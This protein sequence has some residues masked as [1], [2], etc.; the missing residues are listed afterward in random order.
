MQALQLY[1]EQAPYQLQ[2]NHLTRPEPKEGEALVQIRAA[3]LNHRD[4]WIIEGKY[5]GIKT[6]VTLGSDGCGVV[7]A[8]GSGDSEAWI[9][10]EV[11]INPNINW[12]EDPKH[13]S[14]EYN[15]L[16]NPSNGTFATHL[17]CPID[18]LHLKPEHLNSQ[19]AASLPM[20]GLTAYRAV[21]TQGEITKDDTVL[22]SGIGGGVAQFAFQ[23]ALAIGAKVYVT[24]G[25]EHKLQA[26]LKMGALGAVNY[27][28]ENWQQQLLKLSGGFDCA[29]DSAGGNQLNT[30]VRMMK[31]S[32]R[33]ISYGATL[34][35]PEEL[36][37]HRIFYY[38]LKLQ[39]STMG[40]DEEFK[41]M[42]EFVEKHRI[43]PL[44]DMVIPIK[45]AI[46]A[47]NRMKDGDQFG[48]IIL[49]IEDESMMGKLKQ[50]LNVL[51]VQG[52]K[53]LNKGSQAVG[54]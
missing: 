11:I 29:I 3:A 35:K 25:S 32:G 37:I 54:L 24:S 41:E 26:A 1:G 13:Q 23:F 27:R 45:E 39:G 44:I 16:G 30:I 52:K 43:Y 18:R 40:N 6:D 15:I 19:Q 8:V 4:Q 38:Q 46:T 2:I 47:F 34:G 22:I 33:I 21:I 14:K 42:I 51:M 49:Q 50:K 48:K 28:N 31:H 53:A 5:P 10:K 9:G 20:G 36:D 17:L 7:V 12:G